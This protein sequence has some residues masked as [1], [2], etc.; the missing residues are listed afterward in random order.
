MASNDY[1]GLNSDTDSEIEGQPQKAT[2]SKWDWDDPKNASMYFD[3]RNEKPISKRNRK[4]DKQETNEVACCKRSCISQVG[5]RVEN[6]APNAS[7]RLGTSILQRKHLLTEHT[8]TVYRV[9]WCNRLEYK[10]LLLS[11]SADRYKTLFLSVIYFCP[12]PQ[13]GAVDLLSFANLFLVFKFYCYLGHFEAQEVCIASDVCED[14]H[15]T[16]SKRNME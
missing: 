3:G 10:N 14:P 9:H 2:C 16:D 5:D 7:I 11:S 4:N 15:K 6:L 1:F 12:G 8:D 13:S